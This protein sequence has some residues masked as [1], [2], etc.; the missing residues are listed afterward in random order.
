LLVERPVIEEAL[1]GGA[2]RPRSITVIFVAN[3]RRVE[4]ICFRHAISPT[5]DVFALNDAT[6]ALPQQSEAS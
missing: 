6:P 2:F 4:L 5:V 1:T 3:K